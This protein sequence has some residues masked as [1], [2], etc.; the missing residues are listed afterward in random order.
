MHIH[1]WKKKSEKKTNNKDKNTV[2]KS[3]RSF[4][5]REYLWQLIQQAVMESC[6]L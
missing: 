3:M 6:R 5:Y 1:E 4:D 2:K